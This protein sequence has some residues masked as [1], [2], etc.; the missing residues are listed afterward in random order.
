MTAPPLLDFQGNPNRYDFERA[1]K[2]GGLSTYSVS[3]HK[4]RIK[5]GDLGMLWLTGKQS[6]CYALLKV[7]SSPKNRDD[8]EDSDWKIEAQEGD[9]VSVEVMH[10]FVDNPILKEE[11]VEF[12]LLSKLNVGDQG[13]NFQASLG[14]HT[15][16]KSMRQSNPSVVLGPDE[17][18]WLMHCG[19]HKRGNTETGA[20]IW[21]K[22][23]LRCLVTLR[24]PRI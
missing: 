12:P 5:P 14:Q 18:V 2:Q 21:T 22:V 16:L 20:N 8:F 17:R 6:G 10:S 19:L 7:T 15:L 11:C 4:D 13:T 24:Y 9:Y 3:A 23:S 1:L